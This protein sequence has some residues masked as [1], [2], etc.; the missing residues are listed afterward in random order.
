MRRK[1]PGVSRETCAGGV[2]QRALVDELIVDDRGRQRA[3]LF[4]DK[5]A[6]KC[7]DKSVDESLGLGASFR[8]ITRP[9]QT[10]LLFF[11]PE[12]SSGISNTISINAFTGSCCGPLN[13]TPLWLMFSMIPSYQ[14]LVLLTR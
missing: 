8:R 2:P 12:I 14:V 9:W 6:D 10:T 5:A 11:C 4:P 1:A 7:I 13:S 3:V